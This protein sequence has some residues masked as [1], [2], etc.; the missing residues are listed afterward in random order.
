[1]TRKLTLLQDIDGDPQITIFS[2][3]GILSESQGPVWLIGTGSE[4]NVVVQYNI[5]NA[6][7]HFLGVI[8]TESPSW[9]PVPAPPA[10][11]ICLPPT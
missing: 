7:N 9:Q 6:A 4:H 1:M 3:R 11:S 5:A 8:Q 10:V 2:G